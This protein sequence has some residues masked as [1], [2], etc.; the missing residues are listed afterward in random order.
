MAPTFLRYYNTKQGTDYKLDQMTSYFLED[1]TG[2]ST[3]DM[4]KKIQDYLKAETYLEGK[5]VPGSLEAIHKLREKF[6]LVVVTSRDHFFRG[7][8]EAFLDSHFSGLYDELHYTHKADAPDERAPKYK[9][10]QELKAIALIDDH[11]SNVVGCA[12]NGI[13]GLLFGNYPWNQSD[14]LPVGVKRVNNW[15]EVLGYFDEKS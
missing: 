15:Q 10:C 6:K 5:P 1:L 4:L 9:I 11:L 8:T 2:D 12:Q 14:K 7:H 13:E 3:K